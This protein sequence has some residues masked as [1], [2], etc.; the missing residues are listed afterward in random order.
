MSSGLGATMLIYHPVHDVNHCVYRIL[1]ILENSVHEEMDLE[2]YRVQDFY[3]LFPHLLKYIKPFPSELIAYKKIIKRIPDPF[4]L[5]KNTKRIMHDL[6]SLQTVAI[7]SLL[8][9]NILDM[10]AFKNKRLKR[11]EA[12]LPEKIL[13]KIS[14][15]ESLTENWFKMIVNDFPNINFGGNSGLKKRTGLM[16]Y[17][18]DREGL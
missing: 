5:L 18:Y 16:E 7:H 9:K 15:D 17:R 2:L 11:T 1:I 3:F 10:D 6:E 13:A 8:A 14:E 12:M 4:E